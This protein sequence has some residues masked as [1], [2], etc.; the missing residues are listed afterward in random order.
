MDADP[1]WEKVMA[2]RGV[3]LKSIELARTTRNIDNPLDCALRI[4]PSSEDR[5]NLA[6]FDLVD[7]A[8][9]CG[10]SRVELVESDHTN[11]SSMYEVVDLRDD[12]RLTHVASVAGNVM[13]P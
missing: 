3:A 10:V 6:K 12:V 11:P 13:L 8:D 7:L 5:E 2:M 4:I 1:S 9:L